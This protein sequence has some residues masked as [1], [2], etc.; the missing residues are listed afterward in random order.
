MR[1]GSRPRIRANQP[2]LPAIARRARARNSGSFQRRKQP[3]G[4]LIVR[5]RGLSQE[6]DEKITQMWPQPVV[7]PQRSEFA[8]IN[9]P[10]AG[11]KVIQCAPQ[12]GTDEQGFLFLFED[13]FRQRPFAPK[14]GACTEVIEQ[15]LVAK[16][17]PEA[18]PR[19]AQQFPPPPEPATHP[20]IR[21]RSGRGRGRAPPPPP[22]GLQC[23]RPLESHARHALCASAR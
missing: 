21:T 19:T 23:V 20:R 13:M 1:D 22:S 5:V 10:V 6:C 8:A 15:C 16:R 17:H 4:F 2:G 12:H 7:G 11:A 14:E 3:E 18:I 9:R